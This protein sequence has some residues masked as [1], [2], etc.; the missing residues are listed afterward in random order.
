MIELFDIIGAVLGATLRTAS[1]LLFCA[2]AGLVSER[3]GLVEI[4]LEGKMLAAAFAAA[5]LGAVGVPAV[6][7][8][9]GAMGVAMVLGLLHGYACIT[10]RGDQVVSGIAVN[11]IAAGLTTVLG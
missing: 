5:C 4:G 3:A 10:H 7:A 1:P 6:M 2:L 9:A 11:L 8:V